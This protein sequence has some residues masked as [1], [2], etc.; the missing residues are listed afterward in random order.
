MSRFNKPQNSF[1]LSINNISYLFDPQTKQTIKMDRTC[2]SRSYLWKNSLYA[3]KG[4]VW[5][6]LPLQ[7]WRR[8]L[9]CNI[10]P[11]YGGVGWK[12]E[13]SRE[14]RDETEAVT[15]P[16]DETTAKTEIS[17]EPRPGTAKKDNTMAR[18]V[19]ISRE[20][21]T[22]WGGGRRRGVHII[23]IWTHMYKCVSWSYIYRQ[24]DVLCLCTLWFLKVKYSVTVVFPWKQGF[25]RKSCVV[26]FITICG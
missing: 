15:R 4:L 14:G 3:D 17:A 10:V 25:P 21:N 16:R 5:L 26:H 2:L 1:R 18:L 7:E 8:S 12:A 23:H 24:S 6:T 19:V 9:L 11:P 22:R 13:W 20:A